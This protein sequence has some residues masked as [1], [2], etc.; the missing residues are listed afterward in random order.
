MLKLQIKM[1]ELNMKQYVN[2]P[3]RITTD[4]QTM[5]DLV[6]TNNEISEIYVK[7]MYM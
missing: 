5:I 1:S 7:D 2:S 3:T 4:S 6:F